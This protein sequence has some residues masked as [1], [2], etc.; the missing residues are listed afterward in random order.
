M[1]EI[2]ADTCQACAGISMPPAQQHFEA[3]TTITGANGDTDRPRSLPQDAQLWV[4]WQGFQAAWPQNPCTKPLHYGAAL[5]HSVNTPR[6]LHMFVR[7]CVNGAKCVQ[8]H[9][10]M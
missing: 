8:T 2:L 1:V 9:K 6:K 4:A 10:A 7:I 3:S 5:P